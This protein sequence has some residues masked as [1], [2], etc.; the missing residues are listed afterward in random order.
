MSLSQRLDSKSQNLS[1]SKKVHFSTCQTDILVSLF[2][3]TEF[4]F[5]RVSPRKGHCRPILKYSD[6]TD[7]FKRAGST[8]ARALASLGTWASG[9]TSS[10]PNVRSDMYREIVA[11]IR[12]TSAHLR[13]AG[14]SV[15]YSNILGMWG[16]LVEDFSMQ[17]EDYTP[18][19]I[20][21]YD[22]GDVY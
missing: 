10:N 16:Q 19:D 11:R 22:L 3:R 13:H 17:R 4:T 20:E 12:G 21:L 14:E 15:L 18:G 8:F 7:Y 9:V 5:S 6:M 1:K 2:D